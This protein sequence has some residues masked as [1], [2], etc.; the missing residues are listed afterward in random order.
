MTLFTCLIDESNLENR[1]EVLAGSSG[2][3]AV[4]DESL[5]SGSFETS[6]TALRGAQSAIIDLEEVKVSEVS[7]SFPVR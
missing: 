1:Q 3:C 7:G 4:T 6:T 2:H 5:G